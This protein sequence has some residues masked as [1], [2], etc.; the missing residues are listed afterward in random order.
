MVGPVESCAREVKRMRKREREREDKSARKCI[1]QYGSLFV[2]EKSV[3]GNIIIC[4]L[5]IESIFIEA[6][7]LHD[8][9]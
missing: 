5:S 9:L 7:T 2:G 6:K 8:A 4:N 3:C 1:V